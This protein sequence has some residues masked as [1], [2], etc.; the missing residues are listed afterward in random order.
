MTISTGQVPY[1][2]LPTT[3]FRPEDDFRPREDLPTRPDLPGLH[4]FTLVTSL[5]RV[6]R[7]F[8]RRTPEE[9]SRRSR[10]PT[11]SLDSFRTSRPGSYLDP[12]TV[13]S[14]RRRSCHDPSWLHSSRA[15]RRGSEYPGPSRV[16]VGTGPPT[17]PL[18]TVT[19]ATRGS[20]DV[21]CVPER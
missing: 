8:L 16:C 2:P 1:P 17:P 6:G 3:P 13:H 15:S 10:G 9:G 20:G 18:R 7:P 11:E 5:I 12:I 19:P 14:P 21:S 4:Q